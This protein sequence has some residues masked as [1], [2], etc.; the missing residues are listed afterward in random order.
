M[1]IGK[2]NAIGCTKEGNT[3]IRIFDSLKLARIE[4]RKMMIEGYENCRL[5]NRKNKY[6]KY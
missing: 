4:I 2:Y 5:V 6:L 1:K 3:E